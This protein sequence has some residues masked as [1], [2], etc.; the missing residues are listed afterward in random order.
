MIIWDELWP[1]DTQVFENAQVV[2]PILL[3]VVDTL[4]RL[5]LIYRSPLTMKEPDD[6]YVD[7]YS[8]SSLG[9][10]FVR[11]CQRPS[12]NAAIELER[13]LPKG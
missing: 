10:M 4:L 3:I 8:V 12:K 6:T 5:N 11:A 9:L 1:K 2:D 7:R 13:T